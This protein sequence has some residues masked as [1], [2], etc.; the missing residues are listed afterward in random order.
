MG[1]LGPEAFKTCHGVSRMMAE[2][3]LYHRQLRISPLELEKLQPVEL[4]AKHRPPAAIEVIAVGRI[5][6]GG[7]PKLLPEK[8][9]P[10]AGTRTVI[11]GGRRS[12]GG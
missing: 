7:H 6:S 8:S 1:C 11:V 9:R 3:H 2:L 5:L 4:P 12:E 10:E